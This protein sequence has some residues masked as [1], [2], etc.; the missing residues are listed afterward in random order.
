MDVQN[1]RERLRVIFKAHQDKMIFKYLEGELVEPIAAGDHVDKFLEIYA[2]ETLDIKSD[3]ISRDKNLKLTC[4]LETAFRVVNIK[5]IGST[6]FEATLNQKGKSI[7]QSAIEQ[8]ELEEKIEKQAFDV[9][10]LDF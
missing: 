10:Y 8:I 4:I 3:V 9:E 1:L 7:I 6:N 2:K 5:Q